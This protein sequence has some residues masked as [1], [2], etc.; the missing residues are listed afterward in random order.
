M[1]KMSGPEARWCRSAPWGAFAG[2]LV[3]P[4]ALQGER[5]GPEALEIGGGGGAM[6]EQLLVRSPDVHLTTTDVDDAMLDAARARLARFGE[7]AGVESADAAALPFPEER[8]DTVLSF[9]MLHHVIDWEK[10]LAEAVRVLRPGGKLVGYDVLQ[11][12]LVRLVHVA[13]RSPHRLIRLRELRAVLDD[14]PV[15][16]AVLRPGLGGLVV[17]FVLR[18]RR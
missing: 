2:R 7:R 1:P 17:R 18:K 5:V 4:W 15:D 9:I 3:L 6:A 16:Q 8:F 10:A 14:L 12:P 11:S 13:D